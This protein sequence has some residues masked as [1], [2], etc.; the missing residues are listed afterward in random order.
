MFTQHQICCGN[1]KTFRFQSEHR[2]FQQKNKH[3]QLFWI[4][5]TLPIGDFPSHFGDGLLCPYTT[6]INFCIF[7]GSEIPIE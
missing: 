5:R 7:L 3:L 2:H 1:N 4:V 6:K